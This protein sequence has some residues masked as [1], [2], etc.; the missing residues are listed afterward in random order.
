MTRA[1]WEGRGRAGA[2]TGPS[3]GGRPSASVAGLPGA[4]R[5]LPAGRARVLGA[6]ARWG[7]SWLRGRCSGA[8][9][10]VPVVRAWCWVGACWVRSAGATTEGGSTPRPSA[11]HTARRGLHTPLRPFQVPCQAGGSGN[12]PKSQ[13][14]SVPG[15]GEPHPPRVTAMARAK[16]ASARGGP[17]AQS[18][19]PTRRVEVRGE[20]DTDLLVPA[21]GVAP[22]KALSCHGRQ[23][24]VFIAAPRH[25][26]GLQPP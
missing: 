25:D 19:P 10:L 14:L 24:T 23:G 20:A 8:A 22:M 9:W 21:S 7:P 16:S 13:N 6:A 15:G 2:W 11:L 1:A 12:V 18:H 5:G 4:S 3:V 26:W 17:R